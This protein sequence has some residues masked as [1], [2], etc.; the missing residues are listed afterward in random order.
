M[1]GTM[2]PSAWPL[3]VPRLSRYVAA[4]ALVRVQRGTSLIV[5]LMMVTVILV[6]G[7]LGARVSIFSERS[8]RNDRDRQVAFQS[9]EAALLDAETDM[10]GPNTS[11]NRRVCVFDAV[12]P[13]EFVEGCGTD[14]KA[15]MC[16]NGT[17]PSEAWKTLRTDPA[18]A[19][20][21]LLFV[22]ETGTSGTRTVEY[23]QFTGNTLPTG[24]AGLPA[25][26]P[27][28]IIE[29]VPYAGV[30]QSTTMGLNTRAFLVTAVG[31]GTRVETQVMLQSLVYKPA[32]KPN[33]G[34]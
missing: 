7:V 21:P 16:L 25:R 8:A 23:G 1:G 24:G 29:A 18:D 5:V 14:A 31:F 17:Q 6:M 20:S 22:E 19:S 2:R 34:C 28:Y 3:A 12:K 26:L 11:A 32:N 27:R 15:G 4:G 33:S 10:M 9:A 30:D 13:Q